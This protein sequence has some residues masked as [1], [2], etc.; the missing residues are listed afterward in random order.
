MTVLFICSGANL[1][2]ANRSL[3]ALVTNLKNEGI[4]PIVCSPNYGSLLLEL[5]KVGI[6]YW[7][8]PY[9]NWAFTKYITKMYWLHLVGLS[10]N[11]IEQKQAIEQLKN[12]V[13]HHGNI[14][15]IY[16]NSSITGVGAQLAEAT[17]IPHIWHIREFGEADY[18][19]CFGLGRILFNQYANRAK[20]VISISKAI[21]VAVLNKI[22]VPIHT[23]HNGIFTR[24]FL[25]TIPQQSYETLRPFR[26]ILLGIVHPAK[27][28]LQA[29]LAFKEVY[30]INKNCTL[31][32][33]GSGRRDYMLLLKLNIWWYGLQKVVRLKPYTLQPLN[34]IADAHALL[35]CSPHE[36][37]GRV[38]LEASACGLPVIGYK[39]GG[40]IELIDNYENGILYEN[41]KELV[42]AMHLLMND[43][44]LCKKLG[45]NGKAKLAKSYDIKAFAHAIATIIKS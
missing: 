7:V 4:I 21:K 30:K 20:A 28:Q 1:L 3:L 32:I 44:E 13:L 31:N 22:T 39:G 18:N 38:T 19:L 29:I 16:T 12:K 6:S 45:K 17:A 42:A 8:V 41:K 33:I 35:M 37:L 34:E 26:F 9:V 36:G 40:T 27:G 14:D 24:D 15:L 25:A 5:E 10:K 43:T 23:L 2:G 11:M